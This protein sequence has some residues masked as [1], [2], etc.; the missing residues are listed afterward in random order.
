M[1][2][3]GNNLQQKEGGDKY[4]SPKCKALLAEIRP[5]Y[6]KW[7][8]DNE[9]IYGPIG[10]ASDGD[11]ATLKRRVELLNEYKNFIEERRFVEAFDSRSNLQSSALEEFM[12]YLFADLIKSISPNALVGKSHSF[13][14]IFF[15]PPSFS[16]MLLKPHAFVEKKDHDFAIGVSVNASLVTKGAVASEP[17]KWDLPAVAIECKTY[18]DKTM[19]QDVS[20][21]AEE[22]KLR[23]PNA[24]YIVVAE[25]LKL[26]ESVNLKKTKIDQIYIL[27]KQKNSDREVRLRPEY[28]KN[29]IF[30]DVVEHLFTTV[31]DHLTKPWGGSIAAG[32][33]KG[34]LL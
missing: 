31:R 23:N 2:I 6:D 9:A 34:V 24:M 32:L 17:E 10:V 16:E 28:V 33:A 25:W 11:K 12:Y 13:K 4:S 14:D 20:T 1:Y 30:D 22:L 26:T 19:L 3:H 27:R 7:R 8:M 15:R 21:A 5:V 18:L 29:Q